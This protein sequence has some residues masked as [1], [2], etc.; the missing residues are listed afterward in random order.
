[1][2][3]Q[4]AKAMAFVAAD[5]LPLIQFTQASVNNPMSLLESAVCQLVRVHT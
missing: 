5:R 4:K 3:E 2:Q 1:M